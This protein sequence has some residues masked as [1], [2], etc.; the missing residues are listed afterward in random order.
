[1][2]AELAVIIPALNEAATLPLL[3]A[4]LAAQTRVR[5]AVWVSD[6]GSRDATVA[7]ATA[8][9]AQVVSGSPGRGAQMN[10]A[11]ERAG[12][13]LRLFLHADSRLS[14][15]DQLARA[16]DHWQ[17]CGGVGQV[18][19]FPLVFADAPARHARLF[20]FMEA[21]ARSGRPGTI[22]GDQGALVHSDDFERLGR[23]DTRRPFF[24]DVHFSESVFRSAQWCL[25]PDP[26]HTSARR[27]TAEGERERYA[28][29]GLMMA[30]HAAG[31][32]TFFDL[33]PDLYRQQSNTTRLATAPFWHLAVRRVLRQP[34]TWPRLIGYGWQQRWQL[35]LMWQANRQSE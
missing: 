13:G 17:A 29:M 7:L 1:M 28:L 6:G 24:E 34:K 11:H 20:R 32:D 12:S 2:R 10:R 16:L 19:H 21:K 27:F 26:L 14:R 3:L 33:L 25:L 18:G 9:G 15:P 31:D 23:F 22:H 8:T 30:M 5:L 4:D 35:P